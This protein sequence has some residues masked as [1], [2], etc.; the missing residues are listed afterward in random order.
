MEIVHKFNIVYPYFPINNYKEQPMGSLNI[1]FIQKNTATQSEYLYSDLHLDLDNDY[2]IKA[3]FPKDAT[4][5]VD[6]KIDYDVDAIKNSLR[7]IFSTYPGQRLLLPEFG[8]GIERFLFSPVSDGTARAIGTLMN[9][10]IENWEPRVQ[11]IELQIV[12]RVDDHRYDISLNFYIP[13]LKTTANF[14]G[15]VLQGEGFTTG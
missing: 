15:S 1:D 9:Q 6:I 13:S 2:K 10:A 14:M 11:V 12:P 4:R 5:L 7:S 8:I 3:N